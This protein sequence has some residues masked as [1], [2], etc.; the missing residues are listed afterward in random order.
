MSERLPVVPSKD[1][2]DFFV[3]LGCEVKRA[4]GSHLVLKSC[5]NGMIFVIPVHANEDLDRGTLKSILQQAGLGADKFI[6]LW[7]QFR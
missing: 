1:A 7:Q 3:K 6:E 5:F 4:K 2:L